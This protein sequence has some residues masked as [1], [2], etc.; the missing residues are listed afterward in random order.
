MEVAN[1]RWQGGRCKVEGR[2]YEVGEMRQE[3]FCDF[4]YD[5]V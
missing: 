2:W 5:G 1:C 3:F 4:Y